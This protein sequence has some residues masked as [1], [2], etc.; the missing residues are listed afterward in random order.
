MGVEGRKQEYVGKGKEM[1]ARKM[2][3]TERRFITKPCLV[4]ARPVVRV[5]PQITRLG[6]QEKKKVDDACLNVDSTDLPRKTK[7]LPTQRGT[8]S[9]HL[10]TGLGAVAV[11]TTGARVWQFN[12]PPVLLLADRWES[13]WWLL[14]LGTLLAHGGGGG[15]SNLELGGK[16]SQKS[17]Q[18]LAPFPRCVFPAVCSTPTHKELL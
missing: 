11:C 1:Q 8:I 10:E 5:T 16:G 2:R 4:P 3:Q 12:S 14:C 15:I 7:K 17:S 13:W 9:V 18:L 6:N